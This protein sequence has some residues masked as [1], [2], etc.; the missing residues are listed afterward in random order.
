MGRCAR[1][2]AGITLVAAVV[3]P[4]GCTFDFDA[5]FAA[6]QPSEDG[7]TPGDAS[8]SDRSD[9]S[10]DVSWPEGSTDARDGEASIP[11]GC[12]PSCAGKCQ[13]ADDG[14]GSLCPTTACSPDQVCTPS[15]MCCTPGTCA[16]VGAACGVHDDGCG[17]PME[18]GFCGSDNQYCLDGNTCTV[19]DF[20]MR[21]VPAGTFVMGSPTDESGRNEFN[22]FNGNLDETLH[23]VTLTH[24]Y[25]M[26][27]IE[28]TQ[29]TFEAVMGYNPSFFTACGPSCPVE[30]ITRD[31][32]ELFCNRL[33]LAKGLPAC[34][35]CVGAPPNVTCTLSPPFSKPYDC[36]GFRL[37]T[38]AEWERAARGGSSTA[39][40]NGSI[41]E[42][43]CYP[44]DSR[45]HKIGWYLGNGAVTYGGIDLSCSGDAVSIGTH[46]VAQRMANPYGLYDVAGNAW[47]WTMD[48]AAPYPWGGTVVDP[49]SALSCD[50]SDRIFR[51]G[52][53][54]N[55]ASY[56]RHAERA[57]GTAHADGR[58]P[59]ISFRPVRVVD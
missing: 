51:G 27:D 56:C 7:G 49:V 14:C 58:A 52:G 18:C 25:E 28:I 59:D 45:L 19:L 50:P 12:K 30:Q 9:V 55:P 36:P 10:G 37:P 6:T 17:R 44:V 46:P 40:F 2:E 35:D 41:Q 20:A 33:S 3:S 53:V 1:I 22:G 15:G 48:C 57:S 29:A 8:A 13:G 31:E 38:E 11:D 16:S 4:T 23:Q 5:P 26:A 21:P 47:E 42:T 34:F 43:G 24:D 32:A 54:G 39:F